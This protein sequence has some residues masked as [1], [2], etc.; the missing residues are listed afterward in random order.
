MRQA[1]SPPSSAHLGRSAAPASGSPLVR[2]E[3][4]FLKFRPRRSTSP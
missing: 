4:H 2:C 1:V 3:P